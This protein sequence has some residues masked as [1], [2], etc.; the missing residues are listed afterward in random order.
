MFQQVAKSEK[1]LLMREQLAVMDDES[2]KKSHTSANKRHGAKLNC[3]ATRK[4]PDKSL[5][6]PAVEHWD[7]KPE[8]AVEKLRR[9]GLI[10]TKDGEF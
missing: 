3:K 6:D 9:E 1:F 5:A 8:N 2:M 7:V 4:T 10:V